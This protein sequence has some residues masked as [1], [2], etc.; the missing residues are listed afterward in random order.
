M[1]PVAFATF[2]IAD[3]VQGSEGGIDAAPDEEPLWMYEL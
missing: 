2:A 1:T 3:T